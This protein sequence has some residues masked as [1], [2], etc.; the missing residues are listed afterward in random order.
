MQQQQPWVNL[1]TCFSWTLAL[2]ST[3]ASG[4]GIMGARA[5]DRSMVWSPSTDLCMSRLCVG[6]AIKSAGGLGILWILLPKVEGRLQFVRFYRPLLTEQYYVYGH[7]FF[8]LFYLLLA[9]WLAVWTRSLH[10]LHVRMYD[11][12]NKDGL[13]L[14]SADVCIVLIIG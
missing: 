2:C 7:D 6:E 9:H 11:I 10:A 14:V 5:A 13:F 8:P 1:D 4:L 12:P 3:V